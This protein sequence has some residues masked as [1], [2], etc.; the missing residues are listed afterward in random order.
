MYYYNK[1]IENL[2]R[3]L[4]EEEK[5]LYGLEQNKKE[6]L[7][8]IFNSKENFTTFI[9]EFINTNKEISAQELERVI[10]MPN[11]GNNNFKDIDYIY[12]TKDEKVYYLLEYQ[13]AIDK[14]I[15][16]RMLSY[17]INVLKYIY[18]NQMISDKE[19]KFPQIIPIVFYTGNTKWNSPIKLEDVQEPIV[20]ER[21]IFNFEFILININENFQDKIQVKKKMIELMVKNGSNFD[22]INKYIGISKEEIDNFK[23][24]NK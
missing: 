13:T 17:T 9:N 20:N 5:E 1:K 12:R 24:E 3:L 21:N 4:L 23:K 18:E 6:I 8:T 14:T 7:K 16:Y 22:D 11:I 19:F 15:V 2:Y 10:N